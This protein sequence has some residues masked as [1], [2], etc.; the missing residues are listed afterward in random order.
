[1][2][3]GISQLND[4]DH[5]EIEDLLKKIEVSFQIKFGVNELAHI[6]TFG[7]LC[8]YIT[9]KI[10]LN[11]LENCTSQQAFYKLRNAIKATIQPD[12]KEITPELPLIEI[13]PRK[14]RQLRL[15]KIEEQL[16]L[17]L[18]ILQ[19][20]TWVVGTLSI[21]SIASLAAFMFSWQ[22][23]LSGLAFSII[24][25]KLAEMLG[26]ELVLE[27]LGQVAEKMTK[28]HYIKSRR[29][30]TTVNKKEIEKV[31]T[32]WFNAE[33]DITN[34]NLTRNTKLVR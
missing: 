27:T 19:P 31:L 1:M 14:S 15:R 21:I 28:E 3:M 11:H 30:Q 5:E 29:N 2:A 16:G 34:G 26:N 24:G 25:L 17:K 23:A 10:Q 6:S 8:D 12:R 32:D 18:E 4:I 22:L 9:H 20:P 33:F 13:L 7:E